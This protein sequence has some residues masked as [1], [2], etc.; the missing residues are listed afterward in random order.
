MDERPK[1]TLYVETLN[2][3]DLLGK[4]FQPER[5]FHSRRANNAS[6]RR[7]TCSSNNTHVFGVLL[8]C[9][10][11]LTPIPTE[12]ATHLA[13][14]NGKSCNPLS[15]S[16][17]QLYCAQASVYSC[18]N[19]GIELL[20]FALGMMF[21]VSLVVLRSLLLRILKLKAQKGFLLRPKKDSAPDSFL[22]LQVRGKPQRINCSQKSAWLPSVLCFIFSLHFFNESTL[23]IVLR[24]PRK[25][26]CFSFG[27]F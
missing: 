17:L 23:L 15:I 7:M 22:W 5:V 2:F 21:S 20:L 16:I 24:I 10:S 9:R 11:S 3:I 4:D 13:K 14:F 6:L 8:V 12:R 25:R 27:V 1:S 26:R 19:V 18:R